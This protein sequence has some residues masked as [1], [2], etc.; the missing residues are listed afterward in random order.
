MT[1]EAAIP[2]VSGENK[3]TAYAFN[4]D[5]IKSQDA[6]LTVEGAETLKRAAVLYIVTVGID[7]YANHGYD[8]KYALADAQSFGEEVRRQ[9]MKLSTYSHIE[10]ANI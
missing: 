6:V 3:F 7:A 4:H 2:I 1:L 5:N 8:L 10:V 9:Q